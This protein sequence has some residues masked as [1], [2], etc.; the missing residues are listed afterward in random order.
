M[1]VKA[2]LQCLVPS[3]E[4]FLSIC[5]DSSHAECQQTYCQHKTSVTMNLSDSC[6]FDLNV[7]LKTN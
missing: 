1:S 7:R 4:A 5:Q 3:T 6:S 2:E